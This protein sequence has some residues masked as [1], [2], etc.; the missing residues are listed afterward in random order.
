MVS[1]L[2]EAK[3]LM[4]QLKSTPQQAFVQLKH[5]REYISTQR[6]RTFHTAIHSILAMLESSSSEGSV[7]K[8]I[9]IIDNL[10][11]AIYLV[12]K[13][14]MIADDE[15]EADFVKQKIRFEFANTRLAT[16]VAELRAEVLASEQKALELRNE[17]STHADIVSIK[18]K[19]LADW[20]KTCADA[21]SSLE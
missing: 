16:K 14:E 20:T 3:G 7:E 5:F 12:Q 17:I 11:D 4:A 6:Q 19:E 9:A 15:R 10:V 2:N 8:V 1:A 21:T 18:S 13:Q